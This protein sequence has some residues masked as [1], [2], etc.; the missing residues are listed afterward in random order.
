MRES[1]RRYIAAEL[2]GDPADTVADDDD[3]L[4]GG[5]VDSIGLMSLVS[6]VEREFDLVV[7]L[8]DVTIEN[9]LSIATIETYLKQRAIAE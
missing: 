4:G 8:E 7:P 3:L 5:I 1:L 2:R 9:F 6:F